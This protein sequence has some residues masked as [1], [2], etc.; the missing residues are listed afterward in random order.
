[1]KAVAYLRVSNKAN[2][3]DDRDGFTR[4]IECIKQY[5]KRKR[6]EITDVYQDVIS[7]RK[8]FGQRP[9]FARM[10]DRIDSNG[11][12]TVLI[13]RA[14][15]LARDS[16]QSEIIYSTLKKRG[17]K[18]IIAESG[19]EYSEETDNP[20]TDLI[21][22]ILAACSDFDAACISHKLRAARDRERIKK[23][24]CE[25]IKKFGEDRKSGRTGDKRSESAILLEKQTLEA[26]VKL[27]RKPRKGKRLS[28]QAIADELNNR[29]LKTRSGKPWLSNTVRRILM[30]AK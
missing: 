4:Q 9:E 20:T 13:E 29:G 24:K 21:R 10:L 19:T 1:M 22:R 6:M 30:N 23:G 27:R 18:L 26:M 11:V 2:A 25:G 7:G 17:I 3:S 12:R 28:Y 5:A 16:M 8:E 15:R 14:D